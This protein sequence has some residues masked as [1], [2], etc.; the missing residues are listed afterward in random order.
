MFLVTWGVQISLHRAFSLMNGPPLSG[1]ESHGDTNLD[2]MLLNKYVF[3]RCTC[4]SVR[5]GLG[6]NAFAT[7][8]QKGGSPLASTCSLHRN[9]SRAHETAEVLLIWEPDSSSSYGAYTSHSSG[10]LP[11]LGS[12]WLS[13]RCNTLNEN[14][15]GLPD[16]LWLGLK[17]CWGSKVLKSLWEL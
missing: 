17:L 1:L 15:K 11:A 10:R 8:G 6:H 5:A 13:P 7:H 16:H 4:C 2:H 9:M 14:I 12:H 3:R